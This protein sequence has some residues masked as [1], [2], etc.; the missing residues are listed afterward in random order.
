MSGHNDVKIAA[1]EKK[2][3]ACDDFL[4]S[5]L[6]LKEELEK[7][8]AKAAAELLKRRS[9]IIATIDELDRRIAGYSSSP[10]D[11]SSA[12]ITRM[13]KITGAINE[14]LK[15]VI[16]VNQEC[17]ALTVVRQQELRNE[18]AAVNREAEGLRGY[19]QRGVKP[20]RF[21]NIRT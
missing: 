21:L 1:L 15:Q 5:T 2:L 8:D 7:D 18:L 12:V 10:A 13:G 9:G 4:A 11:K 14:R 20:P 17:E 16:V 6:K 19:A 3:K